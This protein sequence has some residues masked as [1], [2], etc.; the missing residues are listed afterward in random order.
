[1]HGNAMRDAAE[2]MAWRGYE[3]VQAREL[4]RAAHISVGTMYRQYGNKRNFAL[5]VRRFTE[6]ELCR[7]AEHQYWLAYSH[8]EQGFRAAFLA[9]W[10][11]LAWVVRTQPGLFCFSFVHWHPED[12][13]EQ[14]R[15][16][17]AK[18]LVRRVLG[19]GE[20]EGVLAAGAAR[21]GESL[22][23]GSLRELARTVAQSS[24]EVTDE[25]VLATGEALLRALEVRGE[26]GPRGG[27]GPAPEGSK[28]Q[29]EGGPLPQD[30]GTQGAEACHQPAPAKPEGPMPGGSGMSSA[31][32]LLEVPVSGALQASE[33][34]P[35]EPPASGFMEASADTHREKFAQALNQEGTA[36]RGRNGCR[37]EGRRAAACPL[38]SSQERLQ[39]SPGDAPSPGG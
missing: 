31:A 28:P 22:V 8:E 36:P 39:T 16:E 13:G 35:C 25:G 37:V 32:D 2:M 1:M 34:A 17:Q 9:F 23:W 33:V 29:G 27:G 4:A 30:S 6:Q 24:D 15:G 10:G 20:T 26:S 38:P 21:V 19:D 5:E 7:Y 18:A 3:K 14:V 11:A 12:L